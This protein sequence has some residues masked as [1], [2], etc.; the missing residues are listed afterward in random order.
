MQLQKK[1]EN[2]NNDE[3]VMP[4]VISVY[5]TRYD[6]P[7]PAHTFSKL[8]GVLP[9]ALQAAIYRY[10]RW[11]DAHAA[12]LGKH[13]LQ[14]ALRRQQLPYTL[15]ELEYTAYRRP[16]I[17]GTPD[18]NI[19]HSGN[20]VACAVAEKGH[21]GIDIE[22]HQLLPME[23]FRQQFSPEEWN[24]I[25]RDPV[26]PATFYRYWT[27]KEAVLKGAGTGLN[28]TLHLLNTAPDTVFY[29][30]YTWQLHPV[31]IAPAYTCHLAC[32]EMNITVSIREISTSELVADVMS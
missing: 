8:A 16:F 15:A 31:S 22:M 21:I 18:F 32:S 3:N 10:R 11:E 30:Q 6:T 26:P 28:D 2:F 19:T 4:T 13:L 5:Y 17:K 24:D 27:R 14:Y 7:M 9:E 23:D 29:D 12:L 1:C 20:I 25:C